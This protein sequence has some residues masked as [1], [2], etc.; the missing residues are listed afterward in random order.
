MYEGSILDFDLKQQDVL[1]HHEICVSGAPS[2]NV[3]MNQRTNLLS[4][5][6]SVENHQAICHLNSNR[7]IS[8]D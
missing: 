1:L 8:I 6:I 2:L 3:K 7:E 5:K 4:G